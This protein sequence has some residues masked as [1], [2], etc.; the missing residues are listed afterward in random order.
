MPAKGNCEISLRLEFPD[1]KS[2]RIAMLSVFPKEKE[3]REHERRSSTEA[4]VKNN[5]LLI[6]IKA[7]D[8]TALKAS[9]NSQLKLLGA[10]IEIL[11]V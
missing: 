7:K 8:R 2:A 5:S 10:A 9:L 11:E 6:C 3:K 1:S 4:R